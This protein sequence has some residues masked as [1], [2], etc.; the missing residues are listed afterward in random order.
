M[1]NCRVSFKVSCVTTILAVAFGTRESLGFSCP[2]MVNKKLEE[3]VFLE[4]WVLLQ[5]PSLLVIY[6]DWVACGNGR[7]LLTPLLRRATKS[8]DLC[9]QALFK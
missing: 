4:S 2:C 3:R 6:T 7:K 1:Q 9:K 5:A 8:R